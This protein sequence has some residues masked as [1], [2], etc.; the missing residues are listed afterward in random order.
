MSTTFGAVPDDVVCANRMFARHDS[1]IQRFTAAGICYCGNDEE[2]IE[3][4][5]RVSVL[6]AAMTC[7]ADQAMVIEAPRRAAEMVPI[8]ANV[9]PPSARPLEAAPVVLLDDELARPVAPAVTIPLGSCPSPKVAVEQGRARRLA[10]EHVDTCELAR[11]AAHLHTFAMPP[12]SSLR[13]SSCPR[14][15]R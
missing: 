4:P 11:L 8:S 6:R 9:F 3:C 14:S 7:A 2:H 10:N 12:A 13:H 15:G 1:M 5:F